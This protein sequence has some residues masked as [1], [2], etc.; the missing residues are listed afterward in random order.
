MTEKSAKILRNGIIDAIGGPG[1]DPDRNNLYPAACMAKVLMDEGFKVD[2]DVIACL[3]KDNMYDHD[4]LTEIE[5]E[6]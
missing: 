3:R 1:G 5:N 4:F 2:D 6:E